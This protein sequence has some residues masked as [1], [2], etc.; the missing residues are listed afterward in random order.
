[1][2]EQVYNGKEADIRALLDKIEVYKLRLSSL[3][4]K[5]L[6]RLTTANQSDGNTLPQQTALLYLNIIQ[7]SQQ[8]LSELRHFLRAYLH[9]ME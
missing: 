8:L 3:R 1:M 7:E 5:H 9:F 4:K 6:D 2:A